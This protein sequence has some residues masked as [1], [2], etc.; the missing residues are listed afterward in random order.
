[1][2]NDLA[3]ITGTD[4]PFPEMRVS[5]HQ[6]TLKEISFIGEESFF[7]GCE[8][9][10]FSKENYLSESDI[11]NLKDLTNFQILI[12]LFKAKE[13]NLQRNK[14]CATMLLSLLF[15]D[16]HIS[17][18]DKDIKFLRE[19]EDEKYSLNNK[20]YE[21]FKSILVEIFCLKRSNNNGMNYN[22]GN[23]AAKAI[24]ARFKKNR[25]KIAKMKGERDKISVFSRYASILAIGQKRDLRS[26]GDYTVYQLL[27]EFDRFELKET[28]DITLKAKMA[29][30]KDVED[31]EDWMKEI[32]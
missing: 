10:N 7:I 13:L 30:A 29:G 2:S 15:P 31:A 17:I 14:V 9:L 21:E 5:I 26:Y 25:A 1:M 3:L 16:Y 11:E 23:D 20:N 18:G 32:H 22:P 6:P 8:F 27:D 4:I 28:Y 12:S 24:A 19:G